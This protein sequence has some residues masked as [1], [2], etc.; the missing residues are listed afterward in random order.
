MILHL[1]ALWS[2]WPLLIAAV[3]LAMLPLWMGR[4]S[5][6]ADGRWKVLLVLRWAASL[7]LAFG[8]LAWRMMSSDLRQMRR[9]RRRRA[10]A[11]RHTRALMGKRAMRASRANGVG[12]TGPHE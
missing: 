3:A 9:Q 11:A 2:R 5:G 10:A 4:P 6:L 1:E 8:A 12:N 7:L